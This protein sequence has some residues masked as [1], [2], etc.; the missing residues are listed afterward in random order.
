[1]FAIESH[2]VS[3]GFWDG[4]FWARQRKRVQAVENV[5][6]QVTPGEIF[7][8][9]GTNG[10]GKST[11]IR[12]IATLLYPDSGHLRI[13]GHDPVKEPMAVRRLINRVAVDAAFFKKLSARENLNYATRLYGLDPRQVADVPN[14][15]CSNWVWHATSSTSPSKI[16]RG[17]CS[18]RLRL[19]GR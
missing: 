5:S 4:P 6:F 12:M 16:C 17:A 15:F 2:A 9:L 7:G 19:R 3:K 14:I 8:L 18:K 13:L 1:M 11:L 10:S